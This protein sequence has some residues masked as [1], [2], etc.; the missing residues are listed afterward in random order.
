MINA[1][2][3]LIT[4]LPR[5]GTTMTCHLLNRLPN[6][7]A[8]HEPMA[9]GKL[10][11]MTPEKLVSEVKL[12]FADQRDMI[13][14][15]GRAKS[16]SWKGT[17]PT[18]H[19]ADAD[20]DGKRSLLIDGNEIEVRNVD[21]PD[22]S[23]CV[24]HPAFFTAALPVLTE[25]FACFAITRN[26]L[27]VLLSWRSSGMAVADG[28]MPSAERFD[29]ALAAALAE[30]N[31][32]LARQFVLMDYCFRQ[33]RR[34]LPG[35]TIK[36]EDIIATGGK[37]LSAINSQAVLLNE[38]LQSRNRLGLSNDPEAIAI[39]KATIDRNSPCWDFYTRDEVEALIAEKTAI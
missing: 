34:F 15:E 5:S 21:R 22:F 20:A 1:S 32:V 25:H 4:G 13:V 23:L 6:S 31:D 30:E 39:A 3:I 2:D 37:V 10:A 26:P 7:V 36:Y 17:V 16:R 19:R 27:S 18:N 12:F 28:R 8:L 11:T 29:P 33:Y 14:R 24:K 38:P 35:R 9:V